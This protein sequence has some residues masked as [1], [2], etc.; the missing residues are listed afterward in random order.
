MHVVQAATGPLR[1]V[2]LA[3]ERCIPAWVARG[4]CF[5]SM[6]AFLLAALHFQQACQLRKQQAPDVLAHL[7]SDGDAEAAAAPASPWGPDDERQLVRDLQSTSNPVALIV[8]VRYA[9]VKHRALSHD[10]LVL[11]QRR[12]PA[13]AP[14]ALPA[15]AALLKAEA[16]ALFTEAYFRLAGV[17]YVAALACVTTAPGA[18]ADADMEFSCHLNLSRCALLRGGAGSG[19]AVAVQHATAAA[20]VADRAA[21][22]AVRNA[23][24]VALW[25]RAEALMAQRRFKLAADDCRQALST[26]PETRALLDRV[27]YLAEVEGDV[28]DPP[29]HRTATTS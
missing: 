16:D 10:D 15:A 18:V 8:M 28:D 21:V 20:A 27:L 14:L 26:V 1:D 12:R 3:D 23:K 24:H 22:T 9:H 11:L 29:P 6:G 2:L 7:A 17:R 19:A 5:A 13:V 25:R 4:R